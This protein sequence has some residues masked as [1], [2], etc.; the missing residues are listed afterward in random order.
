MGAV[1]FKRVSPWNHGSTRF[2]ITETDDLKY[3]TKD[4]SYTD[5]HG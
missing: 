3:I 4:C 2:R 5:V 1:E